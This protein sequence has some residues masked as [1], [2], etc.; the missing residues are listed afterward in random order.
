M[1]GILIFSG[2]N[3]RAVIA[4]LRTLVK[5]GIDEY[6]IVAVSNDTIIK[7]A[8][9]DKVMLIRKDSSLSI[10]LFSEIK[11]NSKFGS[12]FLAPSTEALNRFA[13]DNRCELEAMGYEI[14]LV[15]RKLYNTIS[16]KRLFYQL[17]RENGIK[18]PKIICFPP[19]Y[20]QKFVAKPAFY[21]SKEGKQLSPILVKS[22][23]DY[24]V[25][26]HDFDKDDFDIEEYVEGE[27]FYLLYYFSK[28]GNVYTY[29]QKNIAQQPH[30]KS[31]VAA[32][33]SDTHNEEISEK[34]IKLFRIVG[35]TGLVMVELRK[36]DGE[37]YMIEANPR[38]W[39]PSQLFVSSGYNFFE[40]F[41]SDYGF[42][43]L[44]DPVEIDENIKYLWQKGIL[45]TLSE[46]E[47]IEYFEHCN[48]EWYLSDEWVKWDIYNK[49]DTEKIFG[50]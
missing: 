29:S 18:V 40:Y 27:S 20:I 16:D 30:G 7:S 24:A 6:E 22:E 28:E 15:K 31:I 26:C 36:R 9:A 21:F 12:L 37:Y 8:Y 39:G 46:N 48:D 1:R 19:R 41:L 34:Y 3:Q 5:K 2:Y 17:C 45:D 13:L 4:F 44:S 35:F 33:P 50:K 38:F 49:P 10:E 42:C 25:F 23:S 32:V 47:Q 43:S 11:E 14:P